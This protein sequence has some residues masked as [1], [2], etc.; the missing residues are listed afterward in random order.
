MRQL[1]QPTT[2][3]YEAFRDCRQDWGPGMHEDGFGIEDTD[4]VDTPEGFQ[5]WVRRML[6]QVH[7]PGTPCPDRP[8]WSPRWV[9]EDGRILGGFALRHQHDDMLG[10]VGYGV[11]PSARGQG[12]ATWALNQT[13][14][15]CRDVLGLDRALLTCA[16]DNVASARTIE[17]CGGVLEGVVDGGAEPI[18]RYWV[19]LTVPG[20]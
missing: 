9:V 8:H 12:V 16:V 20:R 18:R 14:A 7:P 1:I 2:S 3:L 17:R 11:R 4:G 19:S 13:L 5:T 6:S 15:E 10:R